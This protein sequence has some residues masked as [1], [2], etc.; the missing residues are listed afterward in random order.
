MAAISSA[1]KSN[2]ARELQTCRGLQE[3][4]WAGK[5]ADLLSSFCQ[6]GHQLLSLE[7]R[8]SE[9]QKSAVL[10]WLSQHWQVGACLIALAVGWSDLRSDIR[11]TQE[12]VSAMAE[13]GGARRADVERRMVE[14]DNRHDARIT[15]VESRAT[16][17][18]VTLAGISA[19]LRTVRAGVDE[20]LRAARATR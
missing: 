2:L 12:R 11:S 4:G 16:A 5:A 7:M 18:E 8:M 6:R 13:L 19:D 15:S 10:D 14:A 20:L 3:L 1:C 9:E 17:A